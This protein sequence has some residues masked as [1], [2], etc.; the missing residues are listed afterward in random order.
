MKTRL[1]SLILICSLILSG[2]SWLDS[3]YVSIEPHRQQ[4]QEGDSEIISAQNY[5]ELM[6]ALEILIAEGAQTGVIHV[7]DY[8]KGS[9]EAGMAVAA[10]Y[11]MTNSPLGAYAVEDIH[12]ELGASS[13]LPA[14]AVSISYRHSQAEIR[15]IR[16]VADIAAAERVIARSLEDCAASVV[17]LIEEYTEKDF[18]QMVQ[19]YAI[20]HPDAVMETPHVAEGI[21]GNGESRVVELLFTYQNS[22][23]SLRQMKKQVERVFNAAVLYVSGDGA[24]RQKFSQLYA[25]LMERFDYT[26]ETSIT[27]AYSLLHHGVGDSRAFATVYASMCRDA[28]LECLVVTGTR[29]G[30]PWTWNMVLDNDHY[31][32]VDLLRC[33]ENG[34]Y[35]ELTDGQM[36]GYVWDYSAY[37]ASADVITPAA[38]KEDVP[39]EETVEVTEEQRPP[40]VTLPEETQP[41]ET[42]AQTQ[43]DETGSETLPEEA[44]PETLP[45]ETSGDTALTESVN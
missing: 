32:H 19:D 26:L 45:Q 13:G 17:L 14:I 21:Y 1:V 6:E 8:K 37:P 44:E 42:M 11:A 22:R 4:H 25:F 36:N 33:S 3:S 43:P 29:S 20:Q 34:Y 30:E 28:G 41:E 12:Y 15:R 2:C 9:I 40:I 18:V 38:E 27:P 16:N 39:P 24:Q 23:D 35:R 5:L 31:Y 7:A 10:A